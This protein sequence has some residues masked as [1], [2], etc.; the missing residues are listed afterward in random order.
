MKIETPIPTVERVI[1]FILKRRIILEAF[2]M[3]ALAEGEAVLI[4]HCQLEKDRIRHTQQLLGRMEGIVELDLLEGRIS[5]IS[6]RVN[7]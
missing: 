6:Q 3:H 5:N 1:Q 4:L 2:Q 7:P